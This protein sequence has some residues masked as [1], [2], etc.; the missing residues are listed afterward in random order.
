MENNY[1]DL[2]NNE[3]ADLLKESNFNQDLI[4][5]C[6]RRNSQSINHLLNKIAVSEKIIED[7]YKNVVELPESSD[8]I[9]YPNQDKIDF[10]N[11]PENII[12]HIPEHKKRL[13]KTL[14][15]DSEFFLKIRV[16]KNPNSLLEY[17]AVENSSIKD[18]WFKQSFVG[19]AMALG[20]G[21]SFSLFLD[22][23]NVQSFSSIAPT[24]SVIEVNDPLAHVYNLASRD[25]K[26]GFGLQIPELTSQ[27]IKLIRALTDEKPQDSTSNIFVKAEIL[28]SI[29]QVISP[30]V[31][32]KEKIHKIANSIYQA[33]KGR[34]VDYLLFLSIMKVETTTFDQNKVSSTGDIS[35]A[36]IKPEVWGP[37]FE[38]LKKAPLDVNRLKQDAA[39]A[40]DRMG[41][42]LEIQNKQ[43]GKDP[44]WYARYHSKTSD[45]KLNYAR[46]V[47]KEYTKIKKAQIKEIEDKIEQI[48]TSIDKTKALK[49]DVLNLR[50][51]LVNEENLTKL[52]VE[53]QKLKKIIEENKDHRVKKMVASL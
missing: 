35:I 16:V 9:Y 14:D 19:S 40:I 23:Q 29:E 17:S 48:L 21:L 13:Y 5:E 4:S 1:K 53:L 38:R 15:D 33:S 26:L 50:K 42:I 49:E 47:Q 45:L 20:V 2:S 31:K 41:E 52:Q 51:F 22:H 36:Q 32:D 8:I 30:Y 10:R 7:F 3:I 44:F 6:I 18:K 34:K 46:K 37:E 28:S 27:D 39:Y 24:H 43:K 25:L 11:L 12:V